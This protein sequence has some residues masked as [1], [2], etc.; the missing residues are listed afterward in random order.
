MFTTAFL[1]IAFNTWCQLEF[2]EK[3]A[4][5]QRLQATPDQL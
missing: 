1:E 3:R 2:K 5:M 4:G